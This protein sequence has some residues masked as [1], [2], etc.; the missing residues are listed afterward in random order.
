[1]LKSN[2]NGGNVI[3]AINIR[4]VATVRYGTGVINW[5]KGQLDKT[6][7]QM[8]KLLNTHRDLY[9]RSFVDLSYI[10]RAQSGRGLWKDLTSLILLKTT[11][12]YF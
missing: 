5:K 10:T 11:T 3:N 6:D 12:R 9:P 8:R 4:A 2:L 7:R 1:M